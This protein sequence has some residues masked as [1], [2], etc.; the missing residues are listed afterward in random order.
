M[1]RRTQSEDKRKD[2]IWERIQK[3]DC[4]Q[5]GCFTRSIWIAGATAASVLAATWSV[6][7]ACFKRS[8]DIKVLDARV[9]FSLAEELEG[10]GCD[11]LQETPQGL[12][13]VM[14]LGPLRLWTNRQ[15]DTGDLGT[16]QVQ[17]DLP[18]EAP[19]ET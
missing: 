7:V 14:S 18:I 15:Y 12:R 4:C 6:C 19:T 17:K 5:S 2:P 3:S 8:G 13:P 11:L 10:L 9:S 16:P 1:R